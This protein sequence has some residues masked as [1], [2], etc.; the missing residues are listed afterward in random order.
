M[1]D[2]A[3]TATT[4]QEGAAPAA[5]A[6]AA[7]ASQPA[8]GTHWLA[9]ADYTDDDRAYMGNKGWDKLPSAVPKPV[10]ESYRHLERIMGDKANAVLLPKL[11]DDKG[12]AEVM[13]KL[14]MPEAADKY[15][16][17]KEFTPDKVQNIDKAT[18]TAY[19]QI[20]HGA[21]MTND[22][23]GVA[24]SMLDKVTEANEEKAVVAYNADVARTK[25]KLTVEFGDQF[26]EQVARGNLAMNQLG[27]SPDE[28]DA[29]SEV[30]GVEKATRLL[31]KMG[32]VLAQHKA[33]GLDN[34]GKSTT[35]FVTDKA[36]AAA[37]VSEIK[38]LAANA[39]GPQADFKKAMLDP[40]HPEHRN[41]TAQWREWNRV[42]NS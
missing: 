28:R 15:T 39:T 1:T 21:K 29:I 19:Q 37:K 11:G 38:M 26:G 8:A 31:M 23:F 25:E 33:V 18:L 40:G 41:A 32:G 27:L 12:L 34:G 6:P 14:G 20:A 35:A 16:L 2:A 4:G 10:Y 30:I 42:A 5:T 22:Q 7:G 9:G 3:A 17:P 13:S 24:M 36:Q